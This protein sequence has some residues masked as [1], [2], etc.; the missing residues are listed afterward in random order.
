MEQVHAR[1]VGDRVEHGAVDVRGKCRLLRHLLRG[2]REG[3]LAALCA[4]H[5]QELPHH[6]R[7]AERAVARAA[8]E[9]VARHHCVQAV[10]R[11]LRVQPARE[12]HRAQRARGEA[13]ARAL[14]L[15]AQEAVIEARVVRHQYPAG[16][17]LEQVAGEHPERGGAGDHLVGD[18]GERLDRTGNA[19]FRIDQRRPLPGDLAGFGLDHRDLG[20]AVVRRM[21]ASGFQIDDGERRVEQRRHGERGW[22]NIQ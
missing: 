1:F 9:M 11:V 10:P 18:A 15:V 4:C 19:R 20:D 7:I 17:A 12:L 13:Q 3:L 22:I 16:E 5:A 6:L 14:E 21:R 8:G 2:L